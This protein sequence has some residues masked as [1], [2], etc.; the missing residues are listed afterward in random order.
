MFNYILYKIG[1]FLALSLPLRLSYLLAVFVSDLRFLYARE[2]RETVKNNLKTIF[3]EKSEKEINRIL[4][5]MFRNFAKYLVDFFRFSNLTK[6]YV[7]KNVRVENSHYVDEALARSKGVIFLTAHIGNWELGGA[8]ISIIGYPLWVVALAHKDKKVNDFFNFQRET[9]GV[10]V[11]PFN[12]AV[13]KCLSVL[14]DNN[15][16]ALVGDRDFTK[17]GGIEVA[18][19]NKTAS[20]PKGPAAFALKTGA[21]IVPGFMLRNKD[22]SFTL[23]FEKPIIPKN[24]D[25]SLLEKTNNGELEKLTKQIKVVLEDYI[26]KYPEQWYMFKQFWI[27]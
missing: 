1:Q 12:N 20:I 25:S 9:K 3:P 7:S 13:R 6:E 24:G 11:I 16:L 19:L 17:E 15:C 14:K 27:A 23:R 4:I 18:F 10:K 22:D 2:D 26:K 5:Q 8:V 21:A